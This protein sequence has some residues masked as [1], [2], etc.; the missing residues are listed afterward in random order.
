MRPK[1]RSAGWA[2]AENSAV[3]SYSGRGFQ[4]RHLGPQEDVV[5]HGGAGAAANHDDARDLVR[6]AA[7]Q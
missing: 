6:K 7:A 1:A 4:D 3:P 5:V 2:A